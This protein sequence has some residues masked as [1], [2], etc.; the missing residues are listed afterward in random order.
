MRAILSAL[1]SV[2]AVHPADTAPKPVEDLLA[3]MR[4]AY[5]SVKTAALEVHVKNAGQNGQITGRFSFKFASPNRIKYLA[6]VGAN[7]TERYCDGKEI[8][9]IR[10]DK[11]ASTTTINVDTLGGEVPG[12]LEW[13]SF[14]DWKR[15][16]STAQ[17]ANMA[18]S[19]FKLIP[20]ESW[21]KKNW[22]V[23]EET[24]TFM[25]LKVRYFI[26]PKSYFIWRCDVSQISQ[27]RQVIHTEVTK[28]E[29]GPKLD[30]SVFKAPPP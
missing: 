11:R 25:N 13:L 7:H 22:I 26:D 30:A 9:T 17:G 23:L 12:N 3:K 29:I 14:F 15:Q 24:A 18:R 27:K 19:T 20:S 2:F 4:K 6:E 8:V 16:L 10:N 5:S 21:N 28:L 1:I